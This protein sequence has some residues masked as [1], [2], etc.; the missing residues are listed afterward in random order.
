MASLQRLNVVAR[1]SARLVHTGVAPFKGRY[2]IGGRSSNSGITA[3]VFGAYG[4]V[5]RYLI[6][7]LGACGS[8]VYVPFRG[9]ELEVR[10]LK[11][12]F[13]LGQVSCS[14]EL[15]ALA[16]SPNL[17]AHSHFYFS[18]IPPLSFS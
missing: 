10:H 7:E 13:D 2:G 6:N 1:S 14:D 17:R 15:E 4:F 3:T 5:G 16:F 12:M 18:P 8:R 11:P 9:C